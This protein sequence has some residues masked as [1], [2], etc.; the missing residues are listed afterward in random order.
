MCWTAAFAH[1]VQALLRA[2]RQSPN[3]S[4]WSESRRRASRRSNTCPRPS[5]WRLA[6]CFAREP[7]RNGPVRLPSSRGGT[8]EADRSHRR[9]RANPQDTVT[10]GLL[11]RDSP[12]HLRLPRGA[13]PFGI[14]A[15]A[16]WLTPLVT[17]LVAFPILALDE[18]GVELQNPFSP[19]HLNH[20]PLDEICEN[21]ERNLLCLLGD[22]DTPGPSEPGRA[23]MHT[24][25]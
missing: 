18:I 19:D 13:L 14:L 21:L 10:R 6:S 9:L 2:Q 23:V 11:D 8:G 17:M 22:A 4:P 3:S 24:P 1:V 25:E 12:V 20:L 5:P 16:D 7:T 15:K